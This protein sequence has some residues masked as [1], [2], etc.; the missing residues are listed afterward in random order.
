MTNLVPT[1]LVVVLGRANDGRNIA[2]LTRETATSVEVLTVEVVEGWNADQL[3]EW[4]NRMANERP[5][6]TRQ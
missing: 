3:R 4:V 5:W 2:L 1:D 6:E